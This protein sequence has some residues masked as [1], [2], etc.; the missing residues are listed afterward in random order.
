MKPHEIGRLLKALERL[1]AAE[2][3]RN[4]LLEAEAAERR[5]SW[6]I[7]RQDSAELAERLAPTLQPLE[8]QPG[9]IPA[10]G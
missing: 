9:V 3:R 5:E 4:E 8:V 10:K 7:M 6:A 2:E 1:A